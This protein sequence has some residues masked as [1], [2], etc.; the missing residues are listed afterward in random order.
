M[1]SSEG[2]IVKRHLKLIILVAVLLAIVCAYFIY[3]ASLKNEETDEGENTENTVISVL[4]MYSGEISSIKYNYKEKEVSLVKK[5]NTWKWADDVDFPMNSVYPDSMAS[6]LSDITALRLISEDSSKY[7]E[8][9]LDTPSLEVSFETIDG[10]KYVYAVGDRNVVTGGYY[11]KLNNSDKVYL[12]ASELS[13]PFNYSIYDMMQTDDFPTIKYENIKKVEFTSQGKKQI[14]T[15][16]R[17]NADFFADIYSYFLVDDRGSTVAADGKSVAELLVAIADLKFEKCESYKPD[18]TMLEKLGFGDNKRTDFIITYDE[19]YEDNTGSANINVS[20]EKTYSFSLGF[21]EDE[22]A[23]TKVYCIREKDSLVVY[24]LE[25]TAGEKLFGMLDA[26]LQSK[27]VCPVPTEKIETF[28]LESQGK[29]YSKT[30]DELKNDSADSELYNK[31]I[32]LVSESKADK[33]IG[34]LYLMATFK[35]GENTLELKVYKY[36]DS[37]YVASFDK[38]DNMLVSAESINAIIELLK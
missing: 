30:A 6:A 36:D 38:F 14:V 4:S 9:G 34:E 33:A 31:V 5:D 8:Y 21:Y 20:T 19:K 25:T 28:T 13:L 3:S 2:K 32:S 12:S 26:E 35:I 37:H 15:T 24:N 17:G 22:E 1:A 16:D 29:T 23:K 7:G 18:S 11:F 10:E 27:Y